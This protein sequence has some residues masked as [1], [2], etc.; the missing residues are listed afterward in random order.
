MGV[1][2]DS[3]NKGLGK[4]THDTARVKMYPTYVRSVP[5]GTGM[6]KFLGFLNLITKGCQFDPPLVRAGCN[7]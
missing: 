2:L 1:M 3:F 7:L 4:E 6:V 5:D